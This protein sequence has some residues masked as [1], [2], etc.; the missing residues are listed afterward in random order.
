MTFVAACFSCWTA[1]CCFACQESTTFEWLGDRARVSPFRFWL[2]CS[3]PIQCHASIGSAATNGCTHSGGLI[4][5]AEETHAIGAHSEAEL[6]GKEAHAQ[7][8]ERIGACG[9]DFTLTSEL[10]A[11]SGS[12]PSGRKGRCADPTVPEFHPRVMDPSADEHLTPLVCA[13]CPR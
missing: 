2:L 9:R 4:Q 1:A 3:V 12:I 7:P 13:R 8:S 11:C 5:A 10:Y 6:T